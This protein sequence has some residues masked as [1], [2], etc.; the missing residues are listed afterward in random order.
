MKKFKKT[1]CF[2]VH[3]ESDWTWS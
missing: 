3:R 2:S 1:L